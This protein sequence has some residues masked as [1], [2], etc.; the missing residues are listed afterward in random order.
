MAGQWAYVREIFINEGLPFMPRAT[1]VGMRLQSRMFK[2]SAAA[3]STPHAVISPNFARECRA[4]LPF[5]GPLYSSF[6]VRVSNSRHERT[7]SR[8]I[9]LQK[10]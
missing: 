4:L 9:L 5:E 8:R 10:T 1:T 6:R 2:L 7:I 3:A